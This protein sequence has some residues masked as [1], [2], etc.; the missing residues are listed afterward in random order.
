MKRFIHF[1][2]DDKDFKPI[3]D[4]KK[5]QVLS[6]DIA[7]KPVL[8]YVDQ[9]EHYMEKAKRCCHYSSTYGLTEDESAAIYLYTDDWGD[10]SLHNVL[11]RTL[12]TRNKIQLEPWLDFLKLFYTALEK[13]P[14]VKE[15]LW[16]GLPIDISK[17][18]EEDDELILCCVTSCSLSIDIMGCF[19]E[20]NPILCSIESFNGKDIR[21]YTPN[22]DIDHRE[23][24][25]TASTNAM[26]D[27]SSP[28]KKK[29][30]EDEIKVVTTFFNGDQYK[31]KYRNGKKQNYAKYYKVN[32]EKVEGKDA[33]DKATGEG[34]C[35]DLNGSRYI[36]AFKHGN[37]HGHGILD[38][39]N[40]MVQAGLWANDE[41][42]DQDLK[43]ISNGH[44]YEWKNDKGEQRQYSVYDDK[45]GNKYIG[46]IVDGKAQGLGIRIWSDNNRYEGNFD[47]DKKHGYGIY[48]YTDRDIYKGQW[49]NDE[50]NGEGKLTWAS[51]TYYQ[52]E[53]VDGKRHGQGT[54]IFADG[55]RQDG[56]WKK[57][58]YVS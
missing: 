56:K 30:N 26:N 11:N 51:G 13:L 55:Q 23:T 33:D 4:Y 7:L 37:R 15:T 58:Q 19:L 31:L 48:Y 3:N 24:R 1:E 28:K 17:K 43:I 5:H 29:S 22:T 27:E 46:N 12:Q 57:D 9:L 20:N 41:V 8:S 42:T 35:T 45:N 21:D 14:N 6:L 32:G 50:I 52:G 49:A 25:S 53:F 40:G 34:I 54:L 36:G 47:D 16:R 18:L 39:T 44:F 10:Q 38:D 2:Y